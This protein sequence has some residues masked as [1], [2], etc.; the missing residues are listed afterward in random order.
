VK[1]QSGFAMMLV[2]VVLVLAGTYMLVNQLS[3]ATTFTPARRDHNARVL[4]RAKQAL[5]GYVA[6]RA[7]KSD[8]PDPGSLPCPEAPGYYG[9]PA[10]EGIAANVCAFPAVGRLPWRTL[11]LDKLTDASGEPLWYVIS[12]GWHK[13]AT[14]GPTSYTVINSNTQGQLRVDSVL[15]DSVAL[16][17]A[18]GAPIA[19]TAPGCAG[20]QQAR[21]QISINVV[22]YLDCDNATPADA[23]FTTS[24]PAGSFNDQVLRITAR[25]I[26]PAI[27]AGIAPRIEREIVPALRSVY[28]SN[29][30]GSNVSAAN[31]FYPYAASF[32]PPSLGASFRGSA[33]SCSG[34][35]CQGLL[36]AIYISNP[37]PDPS[38][39]PLC[40]ASATTACDP[41]FVQ[42]TG[43]TIEVTEANVN[44]VPYSL[45]TIVPLILSWS[46]TTNNCTVA[47][48]SSGTP[49]RQ[50]TELRCNARVPGLGG[51]ASNSVRYRVRG[52]ATNVG[53]TFRQF[54]TTG[55]TIQ[56]PPSATVS[57][58]GIANMTFEGRMDVPASGGWTLIGSVLGGGL[59]LCGLNVLGL[60]TGPLLGLE[61]R[62]VNVTVPITMFA[63]APVVNPRHPTLGWFARNEWYRVLY[64][65]ASRG[66]TPGRSAGAQPNC[67]S[68]G[69]GPGSAECLDLDGTSE[70]ALLFL[71]GR[72]LLGT[73]GNNRALNDFLE[74]ADPDN[75]PDPNRDGGRSF[76]THR[77]T[78]TYND[79]AI[80]V[81]TD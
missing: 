7:G 50:S 26:I 39:H 32:A 55:F 5:I 72:S 37:D 24:G 79:R 53:M 8:E 18:P 77:I 48:V 14:T 46:L 34:D 58:A 78:T 76:A 68:S 60:L 67:D 13:R 27:E 44:G 10:Q 9:D 41:N 38:A 12:P 15:N 66:V 73:V 65:A 31:P 21:N 56:T 11:G 33:G 80:V 23:S 71:A 16:I 20:I 51:T 28:A 74:D 54:D 61:C 47:T 45:G 22:N 29:A 49:A 70:R 63:D 30:W 69:P 36:P 35:A 3:A 52:T 17:I 62:E 4:N 6:M 57:N 59:D 43:G 25:D 81:Q 19:S 2:L 1:R 42:W 40:V 75:P 64:F